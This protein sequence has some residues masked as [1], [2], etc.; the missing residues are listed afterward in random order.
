MEPNRVFEQDV[1]GFRD[2]VLH[3]IAR[4]DTDSA[5]VVAGMADIIGLVAAS[6][7]LRGDAVPLDARLDL[8]ISRVRGMHD[9]TLLRATVASSE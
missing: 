1:A 8:V 7:A 3:L 5:I 9:R 2:K 4:D 6:L